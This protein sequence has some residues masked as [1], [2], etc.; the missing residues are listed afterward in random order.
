MARVWQTLV[1]KYID[2]QDVTEYSVIDIITAICSLQGLDLSQRHYRG[3]RKY[4]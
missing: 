1:I 2:S 3:P 4:S